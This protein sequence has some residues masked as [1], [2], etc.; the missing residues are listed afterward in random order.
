MLLICK[1][2]RGSNVAFPWTSDRMWL[3]EQE[4]TDIGNYRQEFRI[5][6]VEE[7]RPIGCI[8][9]EYEERSCLI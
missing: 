5:L 9:R 8:N 2:H 1:T 7:S 4:S 6:F 3:A